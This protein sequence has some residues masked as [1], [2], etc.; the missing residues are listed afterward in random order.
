MNNSIRLPVF[1]LCLIT[2]TA[3]SAIEVSAQSSSGEG[4]FACVRL[5]RSPRLGVSVRM[6]SADQACQR[7][8]KRMMVV[9]SN[10]IPFFAHASRSIPSD[11]RVGSTTPV[12]TAKIAPVEIMAPSA[13]PLF[14]AVTLDVNTDNGMYVI[15]GPTG[16]ARGASSAVDCVPLIDDRQAGAAQRLNSRAQEIGTASASRVVDPVSGR[17]VQVVPGLFPDTTWSVLRQAFIDSAGRHQIAVSCQARAPFAFR[18]TATLI[19]MQQAQ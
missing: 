2:L 6:V 19:S 11:S 17:V 1:G 14:I 4:S 18:G 12:L 3:L 10:T 8:E 7:N 13:A 9:A 5:E 15:P 16:A